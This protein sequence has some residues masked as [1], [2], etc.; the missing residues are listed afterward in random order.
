LG[1]KFVVQTSIIEKHRKDDSSVGLHMSTAA[2]WDA[3]Q[4]ITFNVRWE[5]KSVL[6]VVSVVAIAM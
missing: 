6:V 3:S 4:D 5:N 1:R 2:A